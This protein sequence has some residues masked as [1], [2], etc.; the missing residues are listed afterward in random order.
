VQHQRQGAALLYALGADW[1][2]GGAAVTKKQITEQD[3]VHQ[4][5]YEQ[6]K[7]V[8]LNDLKGFVSSL[9]DNYEH[10]YGTICHAMSAAMCAAMSAVNEHPQGGI[11]GFQASCVMWEVLENAFHVKAPCSLVDYKNMLYPQYADRFTS[12]SQDTFDWLKKEATKCITDGATM[13]PDV[14][15]HMQS[16]ADGAVPFGLSVRD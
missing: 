6:A 15:T 13:H 3:G 4:Q 8:Q 5:W 7:K 9:L 12:I 1:R 16:I 2:I 10:D 14:R 11:T